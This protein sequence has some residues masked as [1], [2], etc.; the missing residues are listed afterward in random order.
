MYHDYIHIYTYTFFWL[1]QHT[2]RNMYTPTKTGDTVKILQLLSLGY[3]PIQKFAEAENGTPLHVAASEG[4]VLTSHILVQAGAELDAIDDEKNTP[5]M[6]ACDKGRPSIVKYLL[7][8]GADLTLRGD[9]GMTCLHLA[10]Q[11]GHLD[12]V[13]IILTQNALPRKFINLQDE[14]G[15]TSLVWACENKHE[16]VI[17]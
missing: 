13:H 15:W 14:G 11:N 6:L 8:S 2:T 16:D 5:L 17:Q 3:S 9:D 4:H 1:F 12:C 7:A 10:A